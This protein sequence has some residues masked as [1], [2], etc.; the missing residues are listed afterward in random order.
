MPNY[1]EVTVVSDLPSESQIIIYPLSPLQR[2]ERTASRERD[3]R[4]SAVVRV[5]E[6]GVPLQLKKKIAKN[7]TALASCGIIAKRECFFGI[8]G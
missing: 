5:S 8:P 6:T 2:L 7:L 1:E 4:K 3:R